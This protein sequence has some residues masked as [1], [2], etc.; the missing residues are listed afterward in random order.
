MLHNPDGA[1]VKSMS[2]KEDH[3]QYPSTIF[4]HLNQPLEYDVI[5][6]SLDN[7]LTVLYGSSFC[8]LRDLSLSRNTSVS[9]Q[10]TESL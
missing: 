6:G 5:R 2:I 7:I 8:I 10:D 4:G 9:V 3:L 1:F